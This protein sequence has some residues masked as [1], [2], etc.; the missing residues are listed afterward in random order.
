MTLLTG[1]SIKYNYVTLQWLNI[2]KPNK[3][4]MLFCLFVTVKQSND[5]HDFMRQKSREKCQFTGAWTEKETFFLS[6]YGQGDRLVALI[7]KHGINDDH[8]DI[9]KHNICFMT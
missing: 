8:H 5:M 9:S 3:F 6:N 1:D 7:I 4:K 2:D